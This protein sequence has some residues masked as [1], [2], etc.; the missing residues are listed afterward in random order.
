MVLSKSNELIWSE[1]KNPRI[2]FKRTKNLLEAPI[3]TLRKQ[4]GGIIY[5]LYGNCGK[6]SF[7]RN[8]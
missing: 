2:K 7:L 4:F 8:R 3:C 6:R 1:S 5:E